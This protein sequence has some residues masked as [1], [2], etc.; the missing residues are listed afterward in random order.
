[1]VGIVTAVSRSPTHT[2]AKWNQNGITLV[3]GLGV[4]GD[5]HNG[6]TVKHRSRLLR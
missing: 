2:L 5:A 3:T 6:K 4:E 1:M